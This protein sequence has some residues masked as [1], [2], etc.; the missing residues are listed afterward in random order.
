MPDIIYVEL[1]K[2]PK[3]HKYQNGAFD[4]AILLLPWL[5]PIYYLYLLSWFA[6]GSKVFCYYSSFANGRRGIGK[7]LPNNIDPNL[8]T[9]IIYAFGKV[10]PSGDQLTSNSW[11]ERQPGG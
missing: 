9:H 10:A 5:I 6:D 1:N 4:K 3:S 2:G 7:F 8:C 11:Q